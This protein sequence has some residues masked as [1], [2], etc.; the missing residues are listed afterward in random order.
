MP[1]IKLNFAAGLAYLFK[2]NHIQQADM[3]RD[4]GLN[5]QVLTDY[6]MGRR[7][8]DEIERNRITERLGLPEALVRQLGMMIRSGVPED[9]AYERVTNQQVAAAHIDETARFNRALDNFFDQIREF[10]RDRFGENLHTALAFEQEMLKVM[11]RFSKWKQ[12]LTIDLLSTAEPQ[13][14]YK[15]AEPE[16]NDRP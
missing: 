2:K 3:A 1:E 5:P 15:V 7:K 4:I 6:K 14:E 8:G 12:E 11:P 10:L 13:P 16:P 9:E